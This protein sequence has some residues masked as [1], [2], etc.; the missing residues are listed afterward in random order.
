MLQYLNFTNVLVLR[1]AG[2]EF[3]QLGVAV[4]HIVQQTQRIIHR[5]F[6][7][8][9]AEGMFRRVG[10][11]VSHRPHRTYCFHDDS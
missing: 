2:H 8:G 6:A 3:F 11:V 7:P 4:V 9:D 5:A 10:D 1:E